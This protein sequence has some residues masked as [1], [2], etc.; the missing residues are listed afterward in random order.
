MKPLW[1]NADDLIAFAEQTESQPPEPLGGIPKQKIPGI[2]RWPIRALVLP[3][4]LLDQFAQKLVRKFFK[5]PYKEVG[6]CNR[7]GNCCYFILIPKPNGLITSLFYY[8]NTEINGFYPRQK[9]PL[10]VDGVEM[11]IMGCRYLNKNGSCNHHRLRPTI[12]REWPVIEYFGP[13]K[14]LKGCGYV[15]VPRD[16]KFDPFPQEGLSTKN[17]LNILQ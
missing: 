12:C 9:E 1:T 14:R 4:V 5:T 7:R 17:K 15:A 8:W 2:V 13:P 11:T 10:P 3:F 6:G 16:P